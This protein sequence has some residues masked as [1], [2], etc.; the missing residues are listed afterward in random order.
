[1]GE[2]QYE[3]RKFMWCKP[4]KRPCWYEDQNRPYGT[5]MIEPDCKHCDLM[6]SKKC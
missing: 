2:K 3:I 6:R 5:P 1:M 4:L